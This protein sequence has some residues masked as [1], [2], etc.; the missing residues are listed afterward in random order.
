MLK[1]PNRGLDIGAKF[2]AIAYLIKE[3]KGVIIY[4]FYIQKRMLF[5]NEYFEPL[6]SSLNEE[7]INT[8][9]HD[10]YF[11]DLEWKIVGDTM[12][13]ITALPEEKFVVCKERNLI[14]RNG[15]LNYMKA[16]NDCNTFIEGNVYLLSKNIIDILFTDP[17]IYNMLNRP[18]DFDGNWARITYDLKGNAKEMYTEF[19][20]SRLAPRYE[21]GHPKEELSRDA[22]FENAFERIIL[23]FCNNPKKMEKKTF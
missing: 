13:P 20:K 2:C 5:E 12:Y 3:K 1:I 11:P 7:F 15:L 14:Y 6:I 18:N 17:L 8:N 21:R 19:K 4:Y 10:A 16:K 23:N 22:Y 9:T